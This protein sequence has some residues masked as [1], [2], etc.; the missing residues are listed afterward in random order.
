MKTDPQLIALIAG[1][2]AAYRNDSVL[3]AAQRD[4]EHMALA[5]MDYSTDPTP[6]ELE[7]ARRVASALDKAYRKTFAELPT[8]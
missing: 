5:L 7:A 4:S 6:R 8:R 3:A 1:T 2:L